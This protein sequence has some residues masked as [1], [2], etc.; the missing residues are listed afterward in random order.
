MYSIIETAKRYPVRY[1]IKQ[2]PVYTKAYEIADT[3]WAEI[4]K[5]TANADEYVITAPNSLSYAE[6]A[7]FKATLE[8]ALATHDKIFIERGDYAFL[9]TSTI[10]IPDGKSIR[11][12]GAMIYIGFIS[13]GAN[14]GRAFQVGN[15]GN[16]IDG[17][18]F[19]G[20][21]HGYDAT[22]DQ[23]SVIT[24]DTNPYGSEHL[25]SFTLQ[26][27]L[28]EDIVGFCV[29][30]GA[31]TADV[32]VQ[33]NIAIRTGN[34]LNNVSAYG[35]ITRRNIMINCEGVET[36]QGNTWVLDNLAVHTSLVIGGDST[37]YLDD[38]QCIGNFVW[39]ASANAGISV[40]HGCRRS[41]VRDN[42]IIGCSYG[43]I[44]D[45]SGG[46]DY[47]VY[48][49][50]IENNYIRDIDNHAIYIK[51]GTEN[52]VIKG[53][54]FAETT[55]KTNGRW[56][57][58]IR[59]RIDVENAVVLQNVFAQYSTDIY[60]TPGISQ[61]YIFNNTFANNSGAG[62]ISN[63]GGATIGTTRPDVA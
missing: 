1:G 42:T 27:C 56:Y 23:S 5:Q 47:G 35:S 52:P 49:P 38:V 44:L 41:V 43:I 18:H 45:G 19:I 50:R 31:Y 13:D 63:I 28:F 9:V 3:L 24:L 17:L 48:D 4:L 51:D 55:D 20:N 39:R 53:N 60:I 15:N 46:Y 33:D 6:A 12:N 59:I 37:R 40:A 2:H 34:G 62:T 8:T 29:N 61:A 11:S 26:N 36:A 58:N 22:N 21:K 54:T 30:G 14:S 25:G 16:T 32:I 7:A 10:T 57:E